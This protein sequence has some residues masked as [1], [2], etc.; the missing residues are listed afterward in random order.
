MKI[1]GPNLRIANVLTGTGP[2]EQQM[3]TLFAKYYSLAKLVQDITNND[4]RNL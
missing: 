3:G 4:F 2:K 1:D